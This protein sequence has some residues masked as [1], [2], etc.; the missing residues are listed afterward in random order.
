MPVE[1]LRSQTRHQRILDAAT[2]VFSHR[3]YRDTSVDQIAEASD[4]SKGGVYFHFPNKEAIFLALLDRMAA[5]L[6]D[7]LERAMAGA[8]TPTAK[9]DAALQTMLHTFAS[10]RTLARLFLID[11]LGASREFNGRVLSIQTE[12]VALIQRQLDDAIAQGELG[13]V[14]TEITSVAWFGALFQVV[15]RWLLTGQPADLHDAYPALR[16]LLVRS[17]DLAADQTMER[18]DDR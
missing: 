17:V 5:L 15:T 13:N 1:Q 7:R 12:F 8:V 6:R 14:D 18:Q 10:H 11:A 3:G 9:L 2:L 4:T 16:T